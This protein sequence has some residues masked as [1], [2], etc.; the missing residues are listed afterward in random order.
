MLSNYRTAADSH[1]IADGHF[2]K[3]YR[4][5]PEITAIANAYMT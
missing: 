5:S 2:L 3:D 4:I 1:I